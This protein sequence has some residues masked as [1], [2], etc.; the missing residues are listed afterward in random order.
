LSQNKETKQLS[1][2]SLFDKPNAKFDSI[3]IFRAW[4]DEDTNMTYSYGEL[5]S[6]GYS[7]TLINAKSSFTIDF[8]PY[9]NTF[10]VD[11]ARNLLYFVGSRDTPNIIEVNFESNQISQVWELKDQLSVNS[12]SKLIL[13]PSKGLYFVGVRNPNWPSVC[14][15]QLADSSNKV[16]CYEY[17]NEF[18]VDGLSYLRDELFFV[19]VKSFSEG[20]FKSS[21]HIIDL[22]NYLINQT[23]SLLLAQS[24]R[25]DMVYSNEIMEN[26]CPTYFYKYFHV[27]QHEDRILFFIFENMYTPATK[28]LI[29]NSCYEIKDKSYR[30]ISTLYYDFNEIPNIILK[31][32]DN[33]VLYQYHI[34]KG[35]KFFRYS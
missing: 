10:A 8:S 17:S 19:S 28:G 34:H 3:K 11:P 12:L 13:L 16:N 2:I 6:N 14:K 30:L 4:L 32:G 23:S 31:N 1:K 33:I 25:K 21:A 29:F 35:R 26:V 18:T 22:S 20:F 27:I 15:L 9:N 7:L 24:R 5:M